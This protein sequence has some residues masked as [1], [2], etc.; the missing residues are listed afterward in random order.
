MSLQKHFLN[1]SGTISS[2]KNEIDSAIEHSFAMINQKLAIDK[3]DIVI[4]NSPNNT[5]P[6]LGIGGFSPD[7]YTIFLS[8]DLGHPQINQTI[9]NEILK[10]L[11]HEAHHCARWRGPGY[12]TTLFE[13]L[14]T[15]GLADCFQME[16]SGENQPIWTTALN[17]EELEIMT[18][19]AKKEYW[20]PYNHSSWFFGSNEAKIPRWTGYSLGYSIVKNYLEK[21]AQ[22]A[23]KI[24]D[25]PAKTIFDSMNS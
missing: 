23:S 13:A 12:G 24:S 16:I 6:E 20:L 2:F 1:S 10:T 4:Q 9:Q 11:A 7:G 14:V 5:I 19:K 3:L 8:L 22:K 15:E 25:I 21:T 18:I 17:K